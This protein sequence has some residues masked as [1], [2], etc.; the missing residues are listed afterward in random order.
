MLSFILDEKRMEV[1]P[2]FS[3]KK[4]FI[5]LDGE[6]T[7][8]LTDLSKT[9]EVMSTLPEYFKWSQMQIARDMKEEFLMVSD[10]MLENQ[11]GKQVD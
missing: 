10:D 8:Q 2:R 4:K 7:L 1:R 9:P 11:A 3:F 5:M 6:E